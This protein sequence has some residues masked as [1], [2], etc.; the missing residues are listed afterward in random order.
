MLTCTAWAEVID[1][2]LEVGEGCGAVCPDVSPVGFLL[3]RGQH[4]HG[5]FVG[6]DHALRQYRLAQGVDLWLELYAGLSDPLRQ[7]RTR[8]SQ[9]STA[10]DLLLPVQRQMIGVFGHHD[11]SHRQ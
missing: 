8:D 3:A 11:M 9:T 10:K 6:V 2:C 7:C 4:L 5:G 1:H